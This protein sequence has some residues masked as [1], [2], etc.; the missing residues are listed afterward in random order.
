MDITDNDTPQVLRR[1][2]VRVPLRIPVRGI[3]F[4]TATLVRGTMGWGESSPMPGYP[5]AAANCDRAA[6]EAAV[7]GLPDTTRTAVPVNAL[8]PEENPTD[9]ADHA[10]RAV[11]AGY[12]TLKLKVGDDG[13]VER[14][15]AVRAA[16][17]DE[18]A[19]RLDANG[20]W[21]VEQARDR[22]QRLARFNPEYIEEPVHGLER[23]AQLRPD[24][25][26]KI[27]ADESVRSIEDAQRLATLEA[28]DVLVVKVQACGGALA[29]IR[30]AQLAEV[31]TVVTSMIETSI[32]LAAGVAAAAAMPELPYACGLGT[33]TL[34]AGDVVSDPLVPVDGMVAVRR[35]EPDEE[36]LDRYSVEV[37]K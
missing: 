15:D 35:P 27:A 33:G 17:G 9:A 6:I 21:P 8:I 31:P 4:R 2:D 20:L 12:R 10:R 24:V 29:A 28:A 26:V 13:E 30:W 7:L 19:I 18:I 34:L 25:T 1:V 36:L 32:G 22:V 3:P 23:L 11:S 5:V 16:V 37:P 14:V